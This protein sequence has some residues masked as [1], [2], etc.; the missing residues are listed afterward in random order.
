MKIGVS[1][2]SFSHYMKETGCDYLKI[3]S[4]AAEMGYDAIEFID[5]LPEISGKSP[6]DTAKEIADCAAKL[7]LTVAAYTVGANL[8]A[9]DPTAEIARLKGCVDVARALGAR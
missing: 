8:L 5:L 4:L 2:Y 1:S 7:G 6:L 9:D 3:C